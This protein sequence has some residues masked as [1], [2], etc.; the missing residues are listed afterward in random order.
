MGLTPEQQ[1]RVKAAA[2]AEDRTE[3]L[4]AVT[5]MESP[6]ELHALMLQYNWDDGF[7]VPMAV[8]GHPSCE[9]GTAQLIYLDAQGPWS[10]PATVRGE[11]ATLLKKAVELLLSGALP[12][13]RVSY[14]PGLDRV[15][16]H[17][18]R[19]AGVPEEVLRRSGPA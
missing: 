11:H 10:D 5:S 16:M 9:R 8:L 1:D 4:A 7:A 14:D 17:K 12:E 18:L 19:R 15:Q 6:E 3:A 13:R 2:S